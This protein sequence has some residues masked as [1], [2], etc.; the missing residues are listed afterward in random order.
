MIEPVLTPGQKSYQ[1]LLV[2]TAQIHR[3]NLK[4][5]LEHRLSKAKAEENQILI[6]QLEEEF[7]SLK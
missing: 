1:E 4:K 6:R 7:N 2:K 5:L 3:T